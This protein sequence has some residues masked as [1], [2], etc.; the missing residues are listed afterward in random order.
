MTWGAA[1]TRDARRASDSEAGKLGEG[2]D[3]ASQPGGC[4]ELRSGRIE[5]SWRTAE[6]RPGR[7]CRRS[8]M[9]TVSR[10]GTTG[11]QKACAGLG[12]A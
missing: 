8:D 5:D 9:F 11:K 10:G 2:F 7:L 6:S 4:P 3:N 12:D 1:R